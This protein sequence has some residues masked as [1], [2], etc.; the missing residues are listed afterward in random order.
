M[1]QLQGAKDKTPGLRAVL[2]SEGRTVCRLLVGAWRNQ[3]HP[4]GGS[5]FVLQCFPGCFQQTVFCSRE[6][7]AVYVKDLTSPLAA[8]ET[9]LCF[10]LLPLSSFFSVHTVSVAHCC[11]TTPSEQQPKT[12]T[13]Y[14]APDSVVGWPISVALCVCSCTDSR[15]RSCSLSISR[16][17]GGVGLKC[18]SQP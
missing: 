13:V 15:W 4:Q 18:P 3:S 7:G 16:R 12:S 5:P 11:V 10:P 2:Q 1:Q 14:L 17:L 6:D 9:A 8:P